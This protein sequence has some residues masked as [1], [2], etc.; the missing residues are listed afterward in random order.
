MLPCVALHESWWY[1]MVR[2]MEFTVKYACYPVWNTL[3]WCLGQLSY[4][5]LVAGTSL[6]GPS[7]PPAATSELQAAGP[8]GESF[9]FV[10]ALLHNQM[11]VPM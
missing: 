4:A 8:S 6:Q 10:T 7:M 1:V 9:L 11:L 2:I 3:V 5:D